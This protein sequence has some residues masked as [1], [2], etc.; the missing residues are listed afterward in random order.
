M[1]LE[2]QTNDIHCKA[3]W[4]YELSTSCL[5]VE[6]IPVL[7]IGCTLWML[8]EHQSLFPGYLKAESCFSDLGIFAFLLR[9]K[10]TRNQKF[11]SLYIYQRPMI[12]NL[13]CWLLQ[14]L[15]NLVQ[16]KS[17][18]PLLS[19]LISYSRMSGT[20]YY[21][22]HETCTEISS[23]Q[24]I[25]RWSSSRLKINLISSVQFLEQ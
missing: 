7:A 1:A 11:K 17:S 22:G 3:K 15:A 9:T 2:Q 18:K 20:E 24:R 10:S 12:V 16:G 13:Y 21:Y 8:V 14:I 4:E 23:I 6:N 5:A 19:L 25:A